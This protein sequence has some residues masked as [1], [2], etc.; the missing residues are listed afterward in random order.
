MPKTPAEA[1]P[2]SRVYWR[3]RD[4]FPDVYQ[5]KETFGWWTTL[6]MIAEGAH[7]SAADLPRKL[8]QPT[9]DKLVKCGLVTLL[10][11]DRFRVLGVEE[12]RARR[13]SEQ[14]NGGTVRAETGVRGP[15]GRFLATTAGPPLDTTAGNQPTSNSKD[16][17]RRDEHR[18]DETRSTTRASGF[19]RVN[20][21]LPDVVTDD[22]IPVDV[23][24][25]Q[26]LADELTQQPFSMNN[27]HGGLGAKA[28][29][30]QLPHGFDRVE[31]AWR[32]VA[33]RVKAASGPNVYPTLRQLVLGADDVLNAIPHADDKER[34]E[35]ESRAAYDRRVEKTRREI[36]ALRGEA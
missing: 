19:E 30:E 32:E 31:K 34:R 10:S 22:P 35:D 28:V 9:L 11:G 29:N 15:D 14:R 12:E 3:F 18:Q 17:T 4:E 20:V 16:E 27:V 8:R 6:L 33:A 25:L 7:P 23:R 36:A 13:N 21:I 26:K 2:Y 24:R 5:D 1:G